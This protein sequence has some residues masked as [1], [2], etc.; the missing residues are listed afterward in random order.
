MTSSNLPVDGLMKAR[1][2]DVL[3]TSLAVPMLLFGFF[4]WFGQVGDSGGES[5]FY[6]GTGAAGIALVLAASAVSLNQILAGRA[7][8]AASPPVSTFL[9]AAAALVIF[10]GIVAKPD[11]IT[12]HVGSIAGLLVAV[13]QAVMLTIGW[14]KGSGKIVKAANIRAIAVEQE[15]AD[16][17]AAQRAAALA[18]MQARAAAGQ[19]PWALPGGQ[20]GFPSGYPQGVTPGY[21]QGVAPG[22]GQGAAPAYPPA[23]YPQ[24]PGQY[25]QAP[26]QYP[27]AGT[28]PPPMVGYPPPPP[29]A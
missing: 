10:G 25:P 27:P 16:A 6:N 29:R 12:L 28:Y 1:I 26:G 21:G 2:W 8:E 23:P 13:T 5:G 22:Y 7:H 9:S 3:G 15:V 18:A 20:Q 14:I 24:A 4:D 19:N 11:S 17:A